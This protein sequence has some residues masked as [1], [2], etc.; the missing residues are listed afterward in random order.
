MLCIFCVA[1]LV[2]FFCTVYIYSLLKSKVARFVTCSEK[3]CCL[4]SGCT[5]IVSQDSKGQIWHA[6]NLDY[7]MSAQMTEV[8][9]NMTLEVAFKRNGKVGILHGC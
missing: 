9:R 1:L 2:R 5:S 7:G 8:M 3:V 6:R 4:S